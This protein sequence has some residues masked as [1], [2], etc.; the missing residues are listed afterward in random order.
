LTDT[1]RRAHGLWDRAEVDDW[2]E[3]NAMDVAEFDRLIRA[4]ARFRAYTGFTSDEVNGQLL[5]DLRISGRY[6]PLAERARDKAARLGESPLEA[7]PRA[8]LLSWYFEREL[9]RPAPSDLD[10]YAHEVGLEDA[11]GLLR[12]LA[13]EH[14]YR[15]LLPNEPSPEGGRKSAAG[16]VRGDP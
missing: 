2:I 15:Q 3:A 1:I 14:R 9:R 10:A 13:D 8:A 16:P 4:E 12:L 6:A 11:A 7:A 5:D